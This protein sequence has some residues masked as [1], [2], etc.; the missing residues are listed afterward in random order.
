M[1]SRPQENARN[2]PC[3]CGSG[4]KYKQC[5]IGKRPAPSASTK[6]W[7]ATVLAV[8]VLGTVGIIAAQRGGGGIAPPAHAH[9]GRTPEPWEYDEARDQHWDPRCNHWHSGPPPEDAEAFPTASTPEPWEYD[10]ANDRHWHPGHSHWHPG[11]PPE[12]EAHEG[13]AH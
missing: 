5:C 6:L 8:A 10:E 9:G 3:P 13:A 2:A 1:K 12:G 4:K 11:P 7:V